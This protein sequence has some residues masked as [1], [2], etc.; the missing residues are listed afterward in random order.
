MPSRHTGVGKHAPPGLR[1]EVPLPATVAAGKHVHAAVPLHRGEALPP[2]LVRD[3]V[4]QVAARRA[5][6]HPVV[7]ELAAAHGHHLW[8]Y[9]LRIVGRYRLGRWITRQDHDPHRRVHGERRE[10]AACELLVRRVPV[11]AKQC[12]LARPP[13]VQGV[14]I[15]HPSPRS[16]QSP[17]PRVPRPA[18]PNKRANAGDAL[19]TEPDDSARK[20]QRARALVAGSRKYEGS[21]LPCYSGVLAGR[22]RFKRCRVKRRYA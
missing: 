14:V 1:T 19:Q 3:R 13:P 18:Y 15:H 17:H 7:R 2:A 4:P 6:H 12:L 9:R 8:Y 10:P 5:A 11:Q 20:E 21:Y 22:T 16:I